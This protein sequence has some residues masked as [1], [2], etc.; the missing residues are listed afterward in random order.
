VKSQSKGSILLNAFSRP[1]QIKDCLESLI[2]ANSKANHPIVVVYQKGNSESKKVLDDFG[3]LITHRLDIEGLFAS[4]LPNINFNRVLGYQFCFEWLGTDWVLAVEED[5]VISPDTVNF[6]EQVIKKENG[7]LFF[8]GINLGSR[9]SS[10][11]DVSTYSKLRFGLHGQ[12]S[13]LTSKTWNH[14]E[15]SRLLNNSV[16]RPFDSQLENYL[17]RGYMATPNRSRFIDSGW[18][19]T[20]A[21]SDPNHEYFRQL[22]ESF[23]N[24][25]DSNLIYC[26]DQAVHYWGTQKL[27]EFRVAGLPRELIRSLYHYLINLKRLTLNWV[28]SKTKNES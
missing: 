19:G 5:V 9:I 6:I 23:V 8:R 13:V 16:K 4:S 20:H 28:D 7:K 18:N 15:A 10:S 11:K 14:F 21:P 2:Q 17:R 22:E 12:C 3:D 24:T 25:F 1:N 26:H 27:N